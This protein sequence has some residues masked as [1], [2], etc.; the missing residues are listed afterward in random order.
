M[1]GEG[2]VSPTHTANMGDEGQTYEVQVC[3]RTGISWR[4]KPQQVSDIIYVVRPQNVDYILYQ[5]QRERKG[6]VT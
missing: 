3:G 1:C 6:E 5:I 4:K 2:E